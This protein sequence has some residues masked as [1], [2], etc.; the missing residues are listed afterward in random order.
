MRREMAESGR[1]RLILWIFSAYSISLA[2]SKHSR[3]ISE[4]NRFPALSD[5]EWEVALTWSVHMLRFSPKHLEPPPPTLLLNANSLTNCPP[6]C[7]KGDSK[8]QRHADWERLG[9]EE[10]DHHQTKGTPNRS[11]P[12]MSLFFSFFFFFLVMKAFKVHTHNNFQISDT[13]VLAVKPHDLFIAWSLYFL[14]FFS[15]FTYPHLWWPPICSI[16][17]FSFYLLSVVRFHTWVRSY[18]TCLSL[19]YS[20]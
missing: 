3:R 2:P 9:Q 17:E 16:H 14:T 18:G 8:W 1:G 13:L 6:V 15:H 19:I 10:L 11:F 7:P 20:T 12:G 5:L 4:Q